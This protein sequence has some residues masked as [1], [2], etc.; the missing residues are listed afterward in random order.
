MFNHRALPGALAALSICAVC[1]VPDVCL[2]VVAP[3]ESFFDGVA[4]G[5]VWANGI[6]DGSTR[7][8]KLPTERPTCG[9]E[10]GYERHRLASEAACARCKKAKSEARARRRA[11]K[12]ERSS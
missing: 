9:T 7:G 10:H 6:P 2:A 4:G 5:R 3:A 12:R 8:R 11:V 1:P